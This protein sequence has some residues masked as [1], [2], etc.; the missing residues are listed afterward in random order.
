MS[1]KTLP[2]RYIQL[3]EKRVT[4]EKVIIDAATTNGKGALLSPAAATLGVFQIVNHGMSMDELNQELLVLEGKFSVG[5]GL[6]HDKFQSLRGDDV[7]KKQDKLSQLCVEKGHLVSALE[8]ARKKIQKLEAQITDLCERLKTAKERL[9]TVKVNEMAIL[10]RQ[11]DVQQQ[12]NVE[13]EEVIEW[14]NVQK[15]A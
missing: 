13:M 6:V 5:N 2:S 15:Q 4:T 14:C 9:M 8:D 11:N 12:F 7:T 1:P 10:S 3:P